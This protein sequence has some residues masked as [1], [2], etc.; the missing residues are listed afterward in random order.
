MWNT[1]KGKMV[2]TTIAPGL[3]EAA[4]MSK[5]M[6][7]VGKQETIAD[8]KAEWLGTEAELE[9]VLEPIRL[10]HFDPGVD[11]P[12]ISYSSVDDQTLPSWARRDATPKDRHDNFRDAAEWTGAQVSINMPKARLLQADRIDKAARKK[13]VLTPAVDLESANTPAALCAQWPAGL[14]E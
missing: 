6:F 2:I 9:A 1:S 7:E 4:V 3:N 13:G 5:T 12:R 8:I 10:T 11:V 14:P